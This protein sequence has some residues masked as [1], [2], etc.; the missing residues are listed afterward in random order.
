MSHISLRECISFAVWILSTLFLHA[1]TAPFNIA[2]SPVQI[3]GLGGLQSFAFGQYQGRWLL[4]GGRLDGLHRRQPFATFDL[5]GHNRQLA[6]VDPNTLQRW[7]APLT[8][9]PVS[10]QEQLASTNMEFYREGN[11]LYCLGGYGSAL[12]QAITSPSPP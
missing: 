3:N 5:A 11:Y 7:V 1:Q 12:P 8:S 9:L 4:V 6:V 10:I 2:L